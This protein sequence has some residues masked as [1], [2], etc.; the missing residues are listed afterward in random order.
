MKRPANLGGNLKHPRALLLVALMG[1]VMAVSGEP[2]SFNIPGTT[3]KEALLLF[4]QQANL[5][6]VLSLDAEVRDFTVEEVAMTGEP[7]VVLDLM[8]K[9]SGLAYQQIAADAFVIEQVSMPHDNLP[10]GD[11]AMV[12]QKQK[13]S[14]LRSIGAAIG[15]VA[16]TTPALAEQVATN[17]RILEEI[18]VTG[19]RK[20]TDLQTTSLAITAISQEQV[21]HSF[22]RDL[23]GIADL[24]PNLIIQNVTPWHSA[25]SVGIRG[26]GTGDIITT[27]DSPIGVVIDD[28][29]LPHVQSQLFDPFDLE[30]V[31]VL[32][33][34]QGTLF[35]KNTTGGV[36]VLR[37]KRP[38]HNEFHGKVQALAGSFGRQEYR[39]AVNVPLIDDTLSFRMMFSDQKSDGQFENDKISTTFGTAA[40]PT[41]PLG[42][43]VNGDGR[44][45]D[46]RDSLYTKFR[47]LWTPN[48]H[49]EALFTYEYMDDDSPT[50][51]VVNET[52]AN[53]TDSFGIPRS[54]LFNALGFPGISQTCANPNSES[55][56]YSSG[57]SLRGDGLAMEQGQRMDVEG[58]YL[59]QKITINQGK[60]DVILGMRE[61]EERLP[62]SVTGEAWPSLFD[63]TR[64][65][66]REMRQAE[67][68]F[69][70]TLES[71]F[72][73]A[74]GAAYFENE[75][76]Y[77][78]FSYL[79]FLELIGVAGR[80][81]LPA[82]SLAIQDGTA[83]GVYGEV[84]YDISDRLR[85]TAGA[86]YSKEEKDFVRGN[87]AFLTPDEVQIWKNSDGA[88]FSRDVLP[89]D[90]Y[91][92]TYAGDEDW[93]DVTF[94]FVLDWEIDDSQFAYFSFNQ[95]FRSG[96]FVETCSSVATC[97]APFDQEE[98]DSFEIGYKA[99][100][101]DDTLRVN[102][103]LFYTEYENVVRSQVV[104]I[105]DEQGNPGQETQFRN[106][107]GAENKGLELEVTWLATSQLSFGL[108]AAW[109]DAEYTEFL[110]NVDGGSGVANNPSCLNVDAFGNDDADCLGI[111]PNFAPEWQVGVSAT[112]EWQL[113]NG[114]SLAART[115]VHAQ[116]E[117]QYS[118]FNSDFTQPQKRTLVDASITLVDAEDRWQLVVFG[119]NMTGEVYRVAGNSVAGLWNFSAYGPR[120]RY[121]AELTVYF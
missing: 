94:R 58:F 103:A 4:G 44:D 22:T 62:S 81:N 31:E 56:V 114:M 9:N 83:I 68:R 61:Q 70:S 96:S 21:E 7:I 42:L 113:S 1:Y 89:L 105:T 38:E 33:G 36:V 69:T 73:F 64:N 79:G 66:E 118:V 54:F 99:D 28:F 80:N 15:L 92:F 34:P 53:G 75:L 51:T 115:F 82:K 37:T 24:V 117:Y 100:L 59:N 63:S 65:L 71:R 55:C 107:A 85:L 25:A 77:R 76:D 43:P 50:K 72:Q 111:V 3:L 98:A 91:A 87:N 18:V 110:T 11:T 86:R 30:G 19:S 20:V 49:Y 97:S 74:V 12:E 45:M 6:I 8:L 102:A 10:G 39:A 95:G 104:P 90:R 101:L 121:G 119:K 84:Y 48:E 23:R 93:D 120:E 14:L 57:A 29:V 78:G 35:G 27:V 109:L 67:V 46:G 26:T 52:P 40:N 88:E 60:F 2:R 47:L 41:T 116:P 16:S 106:I 17:E 32:R 13:K 112:Y 5:T 108:N